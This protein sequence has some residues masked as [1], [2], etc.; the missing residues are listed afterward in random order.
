MSITTTLFLFALLPLTL[1]VYYL[2]RQE[3]RNF[4]LA[5]VSL[6]FYALGDPKGVALLALSIAVNYLLTL[7]MGWNLARMD[8]LKGYSM[9]ARYARKARV[10]LILA[11]SFNFSLL[12]IFKYLVFTARTLHSLLGLSLTVPALALPVGISFYTFRTVSYCVDVYWRLTECQRNPVDLALY[13]SFFPQVTMGPITRYSSF[14]KQ[15]RNR[16]FDMEHFGEGTKLIIAGLF[17]KTVYANG[18]GIFVD[19]IFA[20]A[21]SE[22]TVLLA[23]AG[24]L[25]YLLQLYYDFSGYS[26]MAAGL[27]RLFGFSTPTNFDYPYLSRSIV[28]F[29]NRWHITLGAW[30]RDYLYTPL[31]RALMK[32]KELS[33][34]QC[35]LIALLGVWLF[36]GMWHGAGWRF[37]IY[38]LYYFFFIAL[39]RIVEYYLKKRRKR[40]NLKKQKAS[41]PAATLSRI[42][43]LIVVIFGQLLFRIDALENYPPYFLSMFGLAGNG[44]ISRASVFLIR[45]YLPVMG[46]AGLFCF[47]LVPFL[48]RRLAGMGT[49]PRVIGGAVESVIY[50]AILIISIAYTVAGTYNAFIYFNF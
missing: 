24:I 16:R 21:A 19:Q 32:G 12:F 42:Y 29:W 33:V 48:K 49:I 4:L 1:A 28:E 15:L 40:L 27:G 34:F 26:D 18:I 7:R 25:G 50:T 43:C 31:L 35:N 2:I 3:L 9:S 30:L 36:S 22:R 6:I 41:A 39:E 47:P 38:G 20:M 10:W 37:L 8:E 46:M 5:A 44:L 13:V 14:E 45:E 23:W 11:L 17:K